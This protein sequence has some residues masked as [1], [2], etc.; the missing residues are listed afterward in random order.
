QAMPVPVADYEAQLVDRLIEV[1]ISSLE[2]RSRWVSRDERRGLLD[3]LIAGG[4]SPKVVQLLREMQD[5]DL[6]DVLAQLG[7]GV[8]PKTRLI[9]FGDFY[10][11]QFNWFG[12]MPPQTALTIEAIAKQFIIAGTDGLEDAHLFQV[13]EVVRAG[14]LPALRLIGKPVDVLQEIKIR[15]FEV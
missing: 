13:P 11:R 4:R 5:Y 1:A 3:H 15:L 12:N 8:Q 2:F 10:R 9:R 14:G 7:Y 6:F